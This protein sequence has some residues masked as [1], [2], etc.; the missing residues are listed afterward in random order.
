MTGNEGTGRIWAYTVSGTWAAWN[1]GFPADVARALDP[2]AF[3]WQPV[4]Y[5]AS[6]GPVPPA[7]SPTLP[8]YAESVRQGV[9]ELIRLINLNAGPF[10]LI[11]YSQGAEVTSRV[12]LEIQHGQLAHRQQDLLGGVTFGNPCRQSGHTWPGDTLS[13]HGIAALRIANTPS[14]W[15]DYAHGGDLYACVPDGQAGDNC[16]AVYQAVTQLQIHD[17]VQLIEE[18]LTAFSGKGGLGEQLWELLTN[19]FNLTSVFEAIVIATRFATTQPPT[20]D[21]INYDADDV[22]DGSGRSSLRHAIDHLNAL[23]R[24]AV[25]A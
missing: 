21:H 25:A 14:Q 20:L 8:S 9:T 18:M 3:R 22:M 4:V 19:P 10:V 23:G 11:G 2:N 13:G 16:T 7:S 6:F 1:E 24:Q 5:P 12:L 17:P 15:N